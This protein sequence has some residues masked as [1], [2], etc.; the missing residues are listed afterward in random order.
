[1]PD[2]HGA[3][4]P[5]ATNTPLTIVGQAR[6][7]S[8]A[9]GADSTPNSAY[10]RL[11][12]S[13]TSSNGRS[14]TYGWSSS[15]GAWKTAFRKHESVAYK[16]ITGQ[17]DTQ[18]GTNN[19]SQ[20]FILDDEDGNSWVMKSASLIVDPSQAYE[21]LKDLSG[22][23]QPP[24]GWKFRTVVL[25]QDLVLTPDSGAAHITQD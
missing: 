5:T 4:C 6:G 13:A 23:L 9:R 20:A 11:S 16:T 22:R 24:H 10:S 12:G 7:S 15:A 21:S 1:V 2:G 19:G 8:S 14:V 18:F 3:Q 25:Q 17:R